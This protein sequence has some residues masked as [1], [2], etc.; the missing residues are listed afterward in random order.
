MSYWYLE[1]LFSNNKGDNLNIPT[2]F[3]TLG[4]TN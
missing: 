2:V 3:F 4:E 1:T